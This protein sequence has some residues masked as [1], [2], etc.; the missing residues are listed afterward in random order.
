MIIKFNGRP[1]SNPMLQVLCLVAVGMAFL[2]LPL[3]LLVHAALR[4]FG[5]R[6]ILRNGWRSITINSSS[7]E[8]VQA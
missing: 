7:F 3:W 8:R 1:V 2:L 5:R 4:G 6:G